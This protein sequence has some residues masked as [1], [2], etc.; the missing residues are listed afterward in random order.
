MSTRTATASGARPCSCPLPLP[1]Q[2]S[3]PTLLRARLR[4]TRN[5]PLLRNGH[6]LTAS[7]MLTAVLGGLFWVLATRWYSAD[8]V[9]RSYAALSAA[10]LL[11]G[12]GQFNLG[13]LMTRFLPTAGGRTRRLLLRSYAIATLAS[14]AAAAVFLLVVPAVAPDL[15]FLRSPLVA[16]GFVV[17]TAGYTV[18]VLQ[19]GALTGLR[20]P[21]WVL[22][23][24][25]LFSV[26]KA[27][28]LAAFA[29]WGLQSGVLLSWSGALVVSVTVANV[30]LFRR[31]VPHHQ[32]ESGAAGPPPGLVRYAA[33][34]YA[35]LLLR[36]GAYSVLPLLVL[37]EL[38][39]AQNAYYSLAWVIAYTLYLA[40]L[41]MGSSLIVEAAR[42]PGRLAEHGRRVLRHAALMLAV[43]VA[44]L[45]VAAPWLL[46]LFGREYAEQGTLLLRLLALSAL[47]NLVVAIAVDVA[48]S[49]RRMRTVIGLQAAECGLVLGL[50]VWLVPV[51]GVDGAGVAWLAGLGVLAVPLL[52]T[53]PRWLP[54][55]TPRR[56]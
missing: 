16:A 22:G 39:A 9:G 5:E 23:E 13:D 19:D 10:G 28:L 8:S 32:R 42:D 38:G 1:C 49:R 24:N 47:P 51:L 12:I 14:A 27:A 53:L 21:H 18:F 20:R 11:S 7:S 52:L 31:A 55:P 45:L 35:G 46:S 30:Y 54:A 29:I 37:N 44:V 34:D 15:G 4:A 33:A 6:V 26:L 48:R 3:Y 25:A 2:C 36:L 40:A 41:N 43:A 50:A 56:Q 17:A